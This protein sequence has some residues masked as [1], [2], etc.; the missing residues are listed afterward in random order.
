MPSF[1]SRLVTALMSSSAG[2][3]GST[4]ATRH[5]MA[6]PTTDVR[7]QRATGR[8]LPMPK[9]PQG[10]EPSRTLYA[11]SAVDKWGRL[12]DR[13][14]PL[15]LRWLPGAPLS[16][17]CS[18]NVIVA[19]R[20]ENGAYRLTNQ[21]HL[22]LPASV[23]CAA[24]VRSGDRLLIAAHCDRNLLIAYPV[25][26]LDAMVTALHHPTSFGAVQ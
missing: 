23:R 22:R 8:G 7:L 26:V 17:S 2:D 21:G 25:S 3:F 19:V 6:A 13:S 14:A 5:Q 20:N 9:L 11:M 16:I 12:S 10:V 24:H 1:P 4:G 15:T 18:E